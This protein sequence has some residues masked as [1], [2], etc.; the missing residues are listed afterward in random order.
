MEITKELIRTH[1]KQFKEPE[2]I[3]E[4]GKNGTLVNVPAGEEI[5]GDGKYVKTVP[6]LIQGLVKVIRHE[7]LK[8]MLLYYI[9]PQ[10]SCIVSINCVLHEVKSTVKAIAEA[11]S[12]AIL[13]PSARIGALQRNYTSFN[14]YIIEL[15]Q[16]R[17]EGVLSAYNALAFQSLDERLLAHLRAKANGTGSFVIKA[18]HQELGDELGTARETISRML[19]K[20]EAENQVRLSRGSIEM[21]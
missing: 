14:N 2:L 13:L 15:Y 16:K 1:F 10:E 5:L 8:E 21:I 7:K 3:D 4:I 18:T 11:H 6:L 20:L 9:Y 19:K 17:F 12:Q